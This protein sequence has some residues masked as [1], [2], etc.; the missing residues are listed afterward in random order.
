VGVKSRFVGISEFEDSVGVEQLAMQHYSR[1]LEVVSGGRGGDQTEY[2]LGGGWSG[3]H[4]EGSQIHELFALLMWGVIFAPVPDV[5]Q[6]P[7]QAAPLDLDCA[8]YPTAHF[9]DAAET[10]NLSGGGDRSS[11]AM[12]LCACN[13]FYAARAQSIEARLAELRDL[14]PSELARQVADAWLVN[15]G[16]AVRGLDWRLGKHTPLGLLQAV[17]SCI[18]G[19]VLAA[20]FRALAM[21]HRHF[22]AGLP[23]LLLI[24]A[25]R[26]SG[27]SW[28]VA[29]TDSWL[30]PSIAVRLDPFVARSWRKRRVDEDDLRGE[31]SEN[32]RDELAAVE[33]DEKPITLPPGW[34]FEAQLVE[35][36]GPSDTLSFLQRAWLVII[37]AAGGHCRVCRVVD[38]EKSAAEAEISD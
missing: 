8:S 33:D 37:G 20:M 31:S 35:V 9:A 13:G 36:K 18:G 21:D 32:V 14:V 30:T 1:P 15:R 26:P 6:T 2:V 27:D 17:A 5:F 25:L 28:E 23:D 3:M 34:R 12:V 11:N 19:A 22:S 38:S 29:E 7:F 10:R 24:R 16:S 4:S